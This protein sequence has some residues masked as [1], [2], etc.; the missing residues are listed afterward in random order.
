M[1][2]SEY[3]KCGECNPGYII[4]R[5]GRDKNLSRVSGSATPVQVLP[6]DIIR[7]VYFRFFQNSVSSSLIVIFI[8]KLV[9]ILGCSSDMYE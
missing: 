6:V 8:L 5:T 4:V 7:S 1:F 9:I 3:L 2:L